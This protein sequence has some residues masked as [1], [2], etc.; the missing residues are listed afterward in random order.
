MEGVRSGEE[1]HHV[2]GKV[3]KK[4]VEKHKKTGKNEE[5]R[6]QMRKWSSITKQSSQI[7]TRKESVPPGPMGLI[8]T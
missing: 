3:E 7:I 4:Q 1:H 6:S 2:R 8:W 5:E